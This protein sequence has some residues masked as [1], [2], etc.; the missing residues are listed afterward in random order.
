MK[1]LFSTLVLAFV[2]AVLSIPALADGEVGT[3]GRTCDPAVQQCSQSSS[4][5]DETDTIITTDVG[6]SDFKVLK[7]L[8]RI[9]DLFRL[10]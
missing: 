10:Y 5:A 2:I 7:F 8:F 9:P 6:L 1:K 3:V 4:A